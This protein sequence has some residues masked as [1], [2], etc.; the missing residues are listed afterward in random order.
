MSTIAVPTILFSKS[1]NFN[2]LL[3][4]ET[5]KESLRDIIADQTW[6][7]FLSH[8]RESHID[9]P[10]TA[11]HFDELAGDR[12]QTIITLDSSDWTVTASIYDAGA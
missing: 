3:D 11:E 12:Y 9:T 10:Y 2:E 7:S 1:F 4:T 5:G 6:D 8:V